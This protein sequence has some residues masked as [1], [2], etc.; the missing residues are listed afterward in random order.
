MV[1]SF[2]AV[3]DISN[4]E[5]REDNTDSLLKVVDELGLRASI[6]VEGTIQELAMHSSEAKA[7][8]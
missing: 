6:I 2:A 1:V 7:R 3:K 5:L 8:L 4:N